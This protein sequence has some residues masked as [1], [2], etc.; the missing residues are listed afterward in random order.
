MGFANG[1]QRL[2]DVVG[3]FHVVDI[4]FR[5]PV[6]LTGIRRRLLAPADLAGQEAF[7]QRSPDQRADVLIERQR[8]QFVLR[9]AGL[10]RVVDLLADRLDHAMRLGLAERLHHLPAGVVGRAP[11][12]YLAAGDQ[13]MHRL[14]RLLDGS[15]AIPVVQLVEVD[16]IGAQ[17]LETGLDGANQVVARGAGSVGVIAQRA[18][19]LGGEDDVVALAAQRLAG[20]FFRQPERVEIGGVDQVDAGIEGDIEQLLGPLDVDASGLLETVGATEG[21]RAQRQRRYHQS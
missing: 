11:I 6:A 16:V 14:E 21:H 7:A 1:G 2:D 19:A 5:P 8:H 10:R 3:P 15:D 12:A 20:N 13:M 17:P 9:L 4:G 18:S